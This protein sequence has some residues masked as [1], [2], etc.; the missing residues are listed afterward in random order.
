LLTFFTSICVGGLCSHSYISTV[1]LAGLFVSSSSLAAG[2]LLTVQSGK[3]HRM[4]RNLFFCVFIGFFLYAGIFFMMW[5]L[6]GD[7]HSLS[8]REFFVLAWLFSYLPFTFYF[9][10]ALILYVLPELEDPDDFILAA[11]QLVIEIVPLSLRV[12]LHWKQIHL[13]LK[14]V[15]PGQ[16]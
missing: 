8:Y 16:F 4:K 14:V 3:G 6:L 12:A 5:Q 7:H 1:I 2:A 15:M 9:P 13:D 10:Y 11:I